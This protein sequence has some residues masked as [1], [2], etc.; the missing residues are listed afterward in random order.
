MV[1][2]TGNLISQNLYDNFR[3]YP[4][5]WCQKRIH[6]SWFFINFYFIGSLMDLPPLIVSQSSTNFRNCYKFVFFFVIN[7]NQKCTSSKVSSLP[8]PINIPQNDGI[9][10][11]FQFSTGVSL[12][13]DPI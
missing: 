13:F 3:F 8:P 7:S 1:W 6:P 10:S 2:R 12:D 4:D 11:I 9:Y 5:T